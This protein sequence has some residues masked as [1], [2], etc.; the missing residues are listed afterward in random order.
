M[1]CKMSAAPALVLPLAA[2]VLAM[3]R[4]PGDVNWKRALGL[5]ALSLGAALLGLFV[6]DPFAVLDAPTYLAQLRDQVAIQSGADD[7]WWTRKYVGTWPVLYPWGQL[8]LLGVGPLVGAAGTLG[9]LDFG[10][11]ILDFRR[12]PNKSK[13]QSLPLS[14]AKGP[15]S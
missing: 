6:G 11:W 8:A 7:R 4:G 2:V 14:E 10:F 3:G 1:A 12:N 15:K 9:I 5:A 13:I